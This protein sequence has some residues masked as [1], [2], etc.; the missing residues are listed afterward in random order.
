MYKKYSYARISFIVFAIITLLTG[1]GGG[2]S[3]PQTQPISGGGIKGPLANAI[4]TVYNYDDT[5]PGFKGGVVSTAST[6]SSAAITGL[7]LPFPLNPPYIMEFTSDSG[8]TDLTTGQ[9]PVITI[10]RLQLL[11]GCWIRVSRYM[12]HH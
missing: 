11:M 8:T 4:V 2:D 12:Q 3:A 6:N 5:Q 7:A 10:L 9:P 1:C